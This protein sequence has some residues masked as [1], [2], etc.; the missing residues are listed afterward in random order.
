[1]LNSPNAMDAP[2][3]IWTRGFLRRAASSAPLSE[4]IA[5]IEPRSPYSP[6]PLS[7]TV[8]AI[9]AV[10]SWKFRPNVPTMPTRARIRIRSGRPRT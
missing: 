9:S 8:R 6:A 10:V 5:M 2:I 3:T 1:M 4:P 7:N